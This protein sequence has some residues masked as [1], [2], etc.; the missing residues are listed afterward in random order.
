M[1][2]FF[3]W[4]R[5]AEFHLGFHIR[6]I[7]AFQSKELFCQFARFYLFPLSNLGRDPYLVGCFYDYCSVIPCPAA[8]GMDREYFIQMDET[9][10]A[11]TTGEKIYRGA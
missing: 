11:E 9:Q 3:G 5:R 4:V 8:L 7:F 1:E 10:C 6:N 2:Y